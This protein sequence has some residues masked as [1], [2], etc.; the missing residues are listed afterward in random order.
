MS[1][2]DLSINSLHILVPGGYN[3]SPARS[4][5]DVNSLLVVAYVSPTRAIDTTSYI[6]FATR[7]VLCDTERSKPQ[8]IMCH[9]MANGHSLL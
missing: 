1:H 2:N 6:Q 3:V 5:F 8:L 7:R 9:N 4:A